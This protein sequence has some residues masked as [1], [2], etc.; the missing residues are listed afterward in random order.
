MGKSGIKFKKQPGVLNASS[1]NDNN[2]KAYLGG[3][4]FTKTLGQH[5]LKNPLVVNSIVEK[6]RIGLILFY[7]LVSSLQML[8]LK[9]V[10][11]QEI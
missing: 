5:I 9:S 10:Q 11:V 7:R 2:Q 4:Q 1:E 3:P 6:V 8:Y